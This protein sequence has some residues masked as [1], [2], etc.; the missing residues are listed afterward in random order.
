MVHLSLL[1]YLKR[2]IDLK[3][4]LKDK[5]Y[6]NKQKWT[7]VFSSLLSRGILPRDD[8]DEKSRDIFAEVLESKHPNARI[9]DANSL[10]K[11]NHT[12]Y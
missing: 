4:S 1:I 3:T 2:P 5:L 12:D 8:V 7:L 9:P 6:S 10:P 11:Y